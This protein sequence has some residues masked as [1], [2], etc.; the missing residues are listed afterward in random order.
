[1]E[2]P[3]AAL[4][5]TAG[6]RVHPAEPALPPAAAEQLLTALR[7]LMAQLAREGRIRRWAV[8]V[9]EAGRFLLIAWEDGPGEGMSGCSKD[10]LAKVVALHEA[11]SGCVLTSAPPLWVEIGGAVSGL[12]PAA[13]K[14]LVRSHAITAD[15]PAWDC[16]AESLGGWRAGA[17]A[18]LATLP[19]LERLRQRAA[20][21][22][23]DGKDPLRVG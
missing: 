14:E 12:M 21:A 2:V 11:R 8:E 16:T 1:M 17:R 4:P 7:K 6:V 5:D 9:A 18:A 19:A 3:L 15:T 13:F 23:G 20:P 22:P 10:K